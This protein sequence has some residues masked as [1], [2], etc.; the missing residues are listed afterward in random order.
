M[1]KTLKIEEKYANS[2]INLC[3]DTLKLG[4]QAIVFVGS[5]PS[6]ESEAEK[7]SSK[8]KLT[9]EQKNVLDQ[10]S[11]SI[12]NALE[13]PTK[14]CRRLA[15]CVKFG[16]AFHHS[17]LH[18]KQREIV[19]E[20]FKDG[21]IKIICA[22]PTLAYGLNLPAFRVIVRDLKRFAPPRGMSWIPVL[23][24]LQFC[25]RAGRPD[26]NEEYGEAICIAETDSDKEEI[27]DHYIR[28]EPEDILSKLAVEPILRTHVLSLIST[29]Y[30]NSIDSLM[31][32][33]EKTFYAHQF[34]NI[35][36]IEELI[37]KILTAL[38][39]WEM[40]ESE[41]GKITATLLG[42][43]VSELY[44]DPYT[45]HYLVECMKRTKEKELNVFSLL[46]MVSYT[47]EL[48]PLLTVRVNEYEQVESKINEFSSNILSEE[49]SMFDEEYEEFV[50]SIKTAL[51]FFDWINEADEEALLEGYN[52]RPGELRAKLDLADWLLYGS[53]EIAKLIKMHGLV[54]EMEKARIRLKH[55]AREELLPLLRLEGIG[56]IRARKLHLNKI[57]D[58]EDIKKVDL[59]TLSGIIGKAIALSIKKQV[60]QDLGEEDIVVPKGK[61]RGQLSLGKY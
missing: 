58:V 2:V 10:V 26:F 50:K 14:Q 24:Y 41:G 38:G 3:L 22:T 28:G 6:A 40:I 4:K 48:R 51:F 47:L 29:G 61:R 15:A 20:K 8:I 44:L 16:V 34:Q 11:E 43:R 7:I 39:E 1:Q 54:K 5:K 9:D 35:E 27:F 42:R 18:S 53:Q 36:R 25:G 45:A 21:T 17:G 57:R 31:E 55:G 23:D 19:E 30:A 37:G 49:P 13:K 52:V 32:F 59:A 60:G 56:R 46:H 33:F 12:L